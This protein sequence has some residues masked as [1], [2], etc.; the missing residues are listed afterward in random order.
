MVKIIHVVVL[1][2]QFDFPSKAESISMFPCLE[3]LG[4]Q[5]Q[6]A[7]FLSNCSKIQIQTHSIDK[8]LKLSNAITDW[9]S[10]VVDLSIP[11]SLLSLPTLCGDKIFFPR[12]SWYLGMRSAYISES[13]RNFR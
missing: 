9:F 13:N 3:D 7:A 12:A 10:S 2:S 5:R 8:V 6:F 4:I 11:V 1:H